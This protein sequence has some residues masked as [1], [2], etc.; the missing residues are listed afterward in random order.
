MIF[1]NHGMTWLDLDMHGW[2]EHWPQPKR[3]LHP[4][5]AIATSHNRAQPQHKRCAP[6]KPHDFEVFEV[7]PA[8]VIETVTF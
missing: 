2:W 8:I 7:V 1:V 4:L 3:Q 5:R 6:Q